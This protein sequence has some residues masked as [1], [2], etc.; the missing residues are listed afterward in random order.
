MLLYNNQDSGNC[1]KVRLICAHLGIGLELRE[2]DVVDRSNRPEVL[3]HLNPALRVPV[4]VL[5]D[6]RPLVES[7]AIIG[8]LAEGTPYVFQDPYDRARMLGWQ[9]FEQYEIEP[10]IAVA[11]FLKLFEVPASGEFLAGRQSG[12]RKALEALERGLADR[13][14]LVGGRYSIADMSLFAYTHVAPEGGFDLEPYAAI[15]A[16]I[17]RVAAQPGH[18]PITA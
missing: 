3:G 4:L 13:E 16:W 5:D 6:G 18:I 11:R 7:N 10:N 14:W 1:Y 17:D 12:G 2:L 8:Y 15:R 9:F